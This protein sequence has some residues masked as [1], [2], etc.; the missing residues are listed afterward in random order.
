MSSPEAQTQVHILNSLRKTELD[1]EIVLMER[2]FSIGELTALNPGS[3][4]AFDILTSNLAYVNV[5]G[6]KFAT[7]NIVEQ[8]EHYGLQV[9]EIL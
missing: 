8:N 5:N 2:T 3:V 7:G 6:K 4:L 9:A 1:I